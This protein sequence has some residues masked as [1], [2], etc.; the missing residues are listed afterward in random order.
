MSST[1]PNTGSID[2]IANLISEP[3]QKLEDNLN[4]VAEAVMEEPQDTETDETV[5]VAES[6]DVADHESDEVE[7][8]VDEDGLNDDEAVPF[9]LSDDMELEYKSDGEI[10]KATIGELKRSAAG[11]DYIQKGMEQNAIVKKELEQLTQTMQQDRAKLNDFLQAI[12]NGDVPQKPIIPSKELQESDPFGYLEAMEEYRQNVSQY[13]EFKA[14]ADEQLA[15]DEQL[16]IQEEQKYASEQADVL[17]KEMPELSDPEKGKQLLEDI[18]T[19]AVDYYQVPPHILGSL[20]HT[21]E[22]KIMRDA[23]AYRKLQTSKKVVEKTKGARPMVKAG[24]KKTASSTKV[25]KQKQARSSMQKSGS[26]D[27][28]AKFLLS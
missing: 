2:D 20:K 14:K 1:E 13:E 12:E 19:V 28:V 16:R 17:R 15:A 22:F 6:E 25:V 9:E 5:E 8:I 7:E 11:Q 3:P 18:Q 23:V 24:A 4:E 10:R 27:D 26:V 21:W